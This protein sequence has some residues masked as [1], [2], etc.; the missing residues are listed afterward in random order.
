MCF[1]FCVYAFA[2][3]LNLQ[4]YKSIVNWCPYMYFWSFL[5]CVQ[6]AQSHA[7]YT[8]QPMDNQEAAA[9]P[10]SK[11]CDVGGRV[12]FEE[13]GGWPVWGERA[14]TG[15]QSVWA[16]GRSQRK[17]PGDILTLIQ[18]RIF[19]KLLE[20]GL[21]YVC[22]P[23]FVLF[24]IYRSSLHILNICILKVSLL[25]MTAALFY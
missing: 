6:P 8:R 13:G 20:V 18:P 2:W 1:I 4:Y 19:W 7:A 17:R 11:A 10:F 9:S 22:V 3:K 21:L 16:S 24:I 15:A 12:H 23:F 25:N 14:S 5:R